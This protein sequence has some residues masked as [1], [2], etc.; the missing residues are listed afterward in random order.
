MIRS[1]VTLAIC[2]LAGCDYRMRLDHAC[3]ADGGQDPVDGGWR[4]RRSFSS[5]AL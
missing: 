5:T 4:S 3:P 1:S 2:A